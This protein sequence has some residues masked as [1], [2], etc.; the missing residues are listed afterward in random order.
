MGGL[1][2]Y[3]VKNHTT[4]DTNSSASTPVDMPLEGSPSNINHRI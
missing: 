1:H 4:I 2:I 3:Y